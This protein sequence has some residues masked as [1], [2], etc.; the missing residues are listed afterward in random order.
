MERSVKIDAL[1]F[2]RWIRHFGFHSRHAA[3]RLGI[4]SSTFNAWERAWIE[5]HL[6]SDSR[7]RPVELIDRDTRQ[8]LIALFNLM[9]P[10]VGLP[11]L[12]ATFP[13]VPKRALRHYLHRYR[14]CHRHRS[15]VLIHALRWK[16]VGTVWAIDFTK[17]PTPIDGIYT[18]ILVVRDLASGRILLALPV[19]GEDHQ[20]VADA[21]KA[22]FLQF[23]T[24]L[25]LKSDNGSGFIH[26]CVEQ[27]LL[28]NRVLQLLSPPGTPEYNGACEA[29]IGSL[30]TRAHHES[31]R[32]DR[33]GEWTC[34]D[35]EAARLQ[36]NQTARP[37]GLSQPTPD[38][39]WQKHSRRRPQLRAGFLAE[40]KRQRSVE[41]NHI[42]Q[43]KGYLPGFDL[44]P[45]EKAHVERVAIT[46][47]C[48]ACGLLEFRRRRIT[49]PFSK[50]KQR[51]I[52]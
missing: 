18:H 10:G 21:L 37:Y 40:V 13:N 49:L 6:L 19:A 34:D 45:K 30:K 48:V 5:N 28:Q 39:L 2:G 8:N 33:P 42:R 12:Q 46:R 43:S 24:P 22:L 44:E 25:L 3:G 23:G 9:G 50:R 20:T 11:T 36:A 27:L 52:S 29:G 32:Y 15:Q 26:A 1:A 4:N 7:G 51:K 38:Q 31:A 17:A 41:E 47:A 35:V 14:Y 16:I